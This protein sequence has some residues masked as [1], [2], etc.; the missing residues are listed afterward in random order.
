MKLFPARRTS[1]R[2]IIFGLKV[3]R[4]LCKSM[5]RMQLEYMQKGFS[6]FSQAGVR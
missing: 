5:P 4:I 2:T 1:R 6:E 3:I